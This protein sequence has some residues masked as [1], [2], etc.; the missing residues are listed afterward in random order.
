M[1]VLSRI[2]FF[3]TPG[4]VVCQA[5]LSMELSRQ[6]YWS[7]LQF[8]FPGDLPGPGIVTTSPLSP[9]WQ[10]GS[11]PLLCLVHMTYVLC[12]YVCIYIY[13]SIYII[14]NIY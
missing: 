14:Y 1:Y 10:E 6:K 4:T 9:A 7:R 5:L 12:V 13:I 8:P 2:R 11:S 3:A